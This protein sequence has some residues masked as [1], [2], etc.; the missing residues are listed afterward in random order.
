MNIREAFGSGVS[1][2]RPNRIFSY[3]PNPYASSVRLPPKA[4]KDPDW[5]LANCFLNM[6]DILAV[7][8]EV[9]K[10]SELKHLRPG[11]KEPK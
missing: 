9:E 7:D 4:W 1:I 5:L 11:P 3:K 6:D 10:L 2:R 8:W